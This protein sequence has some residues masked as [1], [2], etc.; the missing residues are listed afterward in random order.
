M[1]QALQWGPAPGGLCTEAPTSASAEVCLLV[2]LL[3]LAR[4][5]GLGVTAAAGSLSWLRLL[6]GGHCSE[7]HSCGQRAGAPP[8]AAVAQLAAQAL[9][10]LAGPRR[11]LAGYLRVRAQGLAPHAAHALQGGPSHGLDQSSASSSE[12][13]SRE[14]P[15]DA[16]HP[17]WGKN[18]VRRPEPPGP[19]ADQGRGSPRA[20]AFCL[21]LRLEL[22]LWHTPDYWS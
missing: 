4:S 20:G 22:I 3:L 19:T 21:A 5:L 2:R 10:R 9:L 18:A 13:S 12:P 11:R 7:A 16:A 17:G 14:L 6:G 15:R 1:L 8:A